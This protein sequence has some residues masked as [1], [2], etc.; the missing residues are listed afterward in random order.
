MVGL[1]FLTIVRSSF[2]QSAGP[3]PEHVTLKVQ[4]IKYENQLF[5]LSQEQSV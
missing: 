1:H 5:A 3:R 2:V 4:Y